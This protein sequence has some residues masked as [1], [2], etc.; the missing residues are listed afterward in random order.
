MLPII[1]IGMGILD[2]GEIQIQFRIQF[3]IVC[4]LKISDNFKKSSSTALK[5]FGGEGGGGVIF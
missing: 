5:I 1:W 3:Q 4:E 2:L